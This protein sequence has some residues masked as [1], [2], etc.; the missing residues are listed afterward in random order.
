MSILV[1]EVSYLDENTTM[2][3]NT[4]QFGR[5]FQRMYACEIYMYDSIAIKF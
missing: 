2:F 4:Q 5:R 1:V 3:D